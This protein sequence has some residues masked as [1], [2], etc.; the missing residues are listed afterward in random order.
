MMRDIEAV[1]RKK[2][3]LPDGSTLEFAAFHGHLMELAPPGYY[4]PAW[5]QWSTTT[6]PIIPKEFVYL[7]KDEA[8][9][10][11]LLDKIKHGGYD[12]LVNACDAGREGELIFW[13]FYETVG[14][15]LP[16]KRYWAQDNTNATIAKAL[17]NLHP[18]SEFAGL[19]QA[20]KWR[21]ELDWLVGM[22]FSPAVSLA[23]NVRANIGRVMSPTLKLIVDRESEIL[24]F[25]PEDYWTV[26]VGVTHPN[27]KFSAAGVL[28]PK[29]NAGKMT[30]AAAKDAKAKTGKEGTITALETRRETL[31]PP[32]LYSTTELQQAGAKVLK[33]SA[34]KTLDI[35]QSLYERKYITYPRTSS[36][37]LPTSFAPVIWDYLNPLATVPELA[38]YVKGLDKARVAAVMKDKSYVD[39][40]K[41]TDHYAIIPTTDKPD[42]SKLSKDELAVYLLIAKRFLSIF[43]PPR[44]TERTV[45]LIQSNGVTY[46]SSGVVEI[47]PGYTVLYP[48]AK[49]PADALPKVAKGDK[50]ALGTPTIK[51]NKT[52]PPKR[53]TTD[54]LLAAMNNV[55]STMSQA[56][57][58]KILKETKGIGTDA[59]R[60]DILE[61][62]E[63]VGL[64]VV[65][66]KGY[67]VPTPF[68][69]N[70]I[71]AVGERDFCS[72]KLTAVWEQRLAQV[73]HGSYPGDLYAE[74]VSY[75]TQE[76]DSILH[77]VSTISQ[78]AT[79]GTCPICG[80]PVVSGKTMFLCQD[81]IPKASRDAGVTDG[82]TFRLFKELLGTTV[83]DEMAKTILAGQH[84]KPVKM[85]TKDGRTF[86]APLTMTIRDDGQ[87]A[88]SPYFERRQA[89]PV[90]P[91]T[92]KAS[93]ILGKCPVCG[94]QVYEGA[95]F[96][97]CVNRD[98]CGFSVSKKIKGGTVR[99]KD[100]RAMLEGKESQDINFTWSSGK[101]GYA[102][103]ALGPDGKLQF[104]FPK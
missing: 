88:I 69:M 5:Q 31:A 67:F 45:L 8:G 64:V 56:D 12:F 3:G 71:A 63:K 74:I 91:K 90:D 17:A 57:L 29:Y 26:S 100:I 54:T 92:L 52:Q 13:S 70:L 1:Y 81:Y 58:R 6:L 20:A 73:E 43:L 59:T 44:V 53:Y 41:I 28:P 4:D 72:P 38:G 62:L 55:G 96:Y 95:N 84:T 80:K 93:D 86:E 32:T 9:V 98:H 48:P 66:G 25:V 101:H 7:P 33:L 103:L 82:C 47:D 60:A 42:L 19:L 89:E 77:G 83:T 16:V 40:A 14:L 68:G 27:G 37:A 21:R 22:N 104:R 61:K 102:K 35:A 10:D 49:K 97:L 2:P 15:T 34:K 65:D 39:N 23:G 99:P 79:V 78:R 18:E 30:E 85:H 11:A 36:R 24:G 50:V 51:A 87:Y 75:I 46:R 76:T 94:G